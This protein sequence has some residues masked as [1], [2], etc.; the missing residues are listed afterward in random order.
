M[1]DYLEQRSMI[2]GAYNAGEL[3]GYARK[4]QEIE[5]SQFYILHNYNKNDEINQ[6]TLIAN[7]TH[8]Y[9]LVKYQ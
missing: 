7:N 3:S 1:I 8:T 9:T 6:Q 2:T 5:P 4:S